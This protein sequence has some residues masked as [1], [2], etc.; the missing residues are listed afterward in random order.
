MAI[1]IEREKTEKKLKWND[2]NDNINLLDSSWR[3]EW[4]GKQAA[5]DSIQ[6]PFCMHNSIFYSNIR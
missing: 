2:N 6:K 5:L 4:N 1:K 3:C